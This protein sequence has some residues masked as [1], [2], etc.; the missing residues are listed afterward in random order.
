MSNQSKEPFFNLKDFYRSDL[1]TAYRNW[2]VDCANEKITPLLERL[3]SAEYILR[4]IQ[5]DWNLNLIKAHFQK[6]GQK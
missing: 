2:A 4:Q 3:T 5:T 6:W 1:Q